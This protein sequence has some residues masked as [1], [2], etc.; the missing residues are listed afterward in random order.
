MC[1]LGKVIQIQSSRS[2]NLIDK[3][4]KI[5]F[6]ETVFLQILP[7]SLQWVKRSDLG[8]HDVS[9]VGVTCLH[10]GYIYALCKTK[11][12]PTIW[13]RSADLQRWQRVKIRSADW[14]G[15]EF[16]PAKTTRVALSHHG[17]LYLLH[18]GSEKMGDGQMIALYHLK[19]TDADSE[20]PV[21]RMFVV[22]SPP[23]MYHVRTA[24]I[25]GTS[26]VLAGGI[27]MNTNTS[28]GTVVE[29]DIR[30]GHTVLN[31]LWPYLPQPV[32]HSWPIVT[33]NK[34]HLFGGA[35]AKPNQPAV[36][37][38]TV[39][40]MN[41]VDA[42]PIGEWMTDDIPPTPH[43]RS[44]AVRLLDH[45][46]VAGGRDPS[47]APTTNACFALDLVARKWFPLPPL[48]TPCFRN[49]L[50]FFEN[51]VVSIGG[52]NKVAE[53]TAVNAWRCQL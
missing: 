44:S 30:T 37:M 4:S 17:N 49:E 9:R 2:Y 7:S 11:Q 15:S 36:G 51:N 35:V 23:G 32:G 53:Q 1:L 18:T 29:L 24:F 12:G 46:L 22:D 33:D 10:R 34:V 41:I 16:N 3:M 43:T 47:G 25:M 19:V 40:T 13:L 28:F 52:S 8:D 20:V 31:S 48:P 50:H 5:V 39:F 21:E 26:L 27:D 38:S 45:I 14:P 6:Q 42:T